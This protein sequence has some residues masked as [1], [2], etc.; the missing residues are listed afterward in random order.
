MGKI[1]D[2]ILSG[3]LGAGLYFGSGCGEAP[4]KLDDYV[5]TDYDWTCDKTP[6]VV[7]VE[8]GEGKKLYIVDP[9]NGTWGS[10]DG[11]EGLV[12][13]LGDRALKVENSTTGVS[14]FV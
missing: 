6:E 14:V 11:V 4:T 9:R 1:R 8:T 13:L 2:Y 12:G 7:A 10:L 5:I 3:A